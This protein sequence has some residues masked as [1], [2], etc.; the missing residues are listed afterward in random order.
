[1]RIFNLLFL[2]ISSTAL[3]GSYDLS[4]V[5]CSAKSGE[6]SLELKGEVVLDQEFLKSASE[7]SDEEIN[8][9]IHLQLRYLIAQLR[10]PSSTQT[11]RIIG[12]ESK[13]QIN[14]I[15]KEATTYGLDRT[16]DDLKHPDYKT[17]DKYQLKA[18]AR[19]YAKSSDHAWRIKYRA[20]IF[21]AICEASSTRS[22]FSNLPYDPYLFY[23]AVRP[24][25]RRTIQWRKS[26]WK[27]NPCADS[28]V[29]DLPHPLYFWYFAD[30]EQTGRDKEDRWF[31]CRKLLSVNR[32]Y[33]HASVSIGDTAPPQPANAL[34]FDRIPSSR[35]LTA[36][37]IFGV[38]D[39]NQKVF[40][41]DRLVKRLPTK[42]GSFEMGSF[43]ESTGWKSVMTNSKDRD[44]GSIYFSRFLTTLASSLTESKWSELPNKEPGSALI[45][46]TGKL[47]R[48]H[49][50]VRLRI[51]FGP[52]D[53]FGKSDPVH[54]KEVL[55]GIT[56][57]D[58]IIY[59]GHSGLGHNLSLADLA[60]GT[61]K[62]LT[63]ISKAAKR[64]AYQLVAY[65]SCFT[66]S[67]FGDELLDSGPR[68]L[69][70]TGSEFTSERGPLGLL[71]IYDRYRETNG[72]KLPSVEQDGLIRSA[73]FIIIKQT[74]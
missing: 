11:P 26:I 72:R 51:L 33:F 38:I 27:V 45:L 3:A 10:V 63:E 70:L 41:V 53:V 1:M 48:S 24:E 49:A 39:P 58:W 30:P 12:S 35:P 69:V 18:I 44:R 60:N 67:Y 2:F 65:L 20:Q 43:L 9:A 21:A 25:D 61:G 74:R 54:W 71:D 50:D 8:D 28:E 22:V 66:Y 4:Y 7:L 5:G 29:A 55:R 14:N 52:T 57:D 15:E 56:E 59:N 23:W 68:D 32:D 64:T 42:P 6:T 40:P 62:S 16:V 47:P 73:D 31:D 19:G 17:D 34:R 46:L 37:V 36:I 13:I